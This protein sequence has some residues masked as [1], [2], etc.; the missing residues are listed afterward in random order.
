MESVIFRRDLSRRTFISLT[1]I[2]PRL[3]SRGESIRKTPGLQSNLLHFATMD[4]V[5]CQKNHPCSWKGAK[6]GGNPCGIG[7]GSNDGSPRPDRSGLAMTNPF[8]IRRE[9]WFGEINKHWK[10]KIIRLFYLDTPQQLNSA[11]FEPGA[12]RLSRRLLP[13]QQLYRFTTAVTP[14]I[15]YRKEITESGLSF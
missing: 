15:K 13:L 8:F 4:K 11:F 14:A 6:R 1:F 3:S 12:L 10:G 7:D 9:E 2:L 5:I